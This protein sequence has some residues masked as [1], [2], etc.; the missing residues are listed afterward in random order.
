LVELPGRTEEWLDSQRLKLPAV[1]HS[2]LDAIALRLE[3]L[4]PQLHGLD[5]QLLEAAALRRLIGEELPELIHGYEKVPLALQ[6]KPLHG[7]AS[8]ERRL[9]DALHTID[10]QIGQLH[11]RIAE[12]D[13]KN[14]ATHQRYLEIKYK[15]DPEL[16]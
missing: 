12:G 3:A 14:L 9:L 1:A 10:E 6:Q 16:K 7:G 15:G 4:T 11:H 5:P 13:L 8:P 2:Q